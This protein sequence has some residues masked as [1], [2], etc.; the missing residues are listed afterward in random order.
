MFFLISGF[1]VVAVFCEG[2]DRGYNN[3]KML[4][5]VKSL[6]ILVKTAPRVLGSGG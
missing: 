2:K 5:F 1:L 4:T 6:L 3:M